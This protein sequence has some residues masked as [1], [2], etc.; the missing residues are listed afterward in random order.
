MLWPFIFPYTMHLLKSSQ[1][2]RFVNQV[3]I[4]RIVSNHLSSCHSHQFNIITNDHFGFLV[5]PTGYN[6]DAMAMKFFSRHYPFITHL[7]V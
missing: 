7:W 5:T 3:N 4:D 6:P 2:E 1:L